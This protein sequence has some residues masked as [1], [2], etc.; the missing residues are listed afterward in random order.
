MLQVWLYAIISV[1]IISVISL[2]GLFTLSI[3]SKLLKKILIYLVS[4]SAGAMFGGAFLHLFPEI[5]EKAGALTL[6]ITSFTLLG[7]VIF[8][9]LEKL[10]LWH[11]CH[12]PL[13]EHEHV[14]SFAIMNLIGDGFH[15]LL[16]GLIIGASYLVSIPTGIAATVAVAFH[17]IP[18]EIGDFGVLIH[19]GF[20]RAKALGVNFLSALAAVVGAV[21]AL[22]A[23]IYIEHIEFFLVPIAIGGFIYIA[24][25]DLIPELNKQS[26]F[27]NSILQLIAFIAGIAV[28]ALLL[29]IG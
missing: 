22:T 24:G 28:M 17:E 21:I 5:V 8:F 12:I 18:Q 27:K 25:S 15:N 9:A 11:H 13:T 7:I 6:T 26:G 10:I 4:F 14:H 20:S 1:L 16:D 19:G 29:L 23:S 2:V 3:K